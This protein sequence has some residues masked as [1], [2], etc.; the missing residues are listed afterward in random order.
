MFLTS[1]SIFGTGTNGAFVE[2]VENITKL[3]D[4]PARQKGG[5]MVVNTEWG[6]FN[7]TVGS[8][9]DADYHIPANID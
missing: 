5:Y 1:G 3:G 2:R 4:S 9:H 7:N 6:A 8:S